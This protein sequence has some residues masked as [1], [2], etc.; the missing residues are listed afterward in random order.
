[1]HFRSNRIQGAQED[2]YNS[3]TINPQFWINEL[4]LVLVLTLAPRR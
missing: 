1:M 3:Q 4:V 2:Y